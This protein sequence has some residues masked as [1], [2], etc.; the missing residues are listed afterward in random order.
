M[1]RNDDVFKRYRDVS[2]NERTRVWNNGFSDYLVPINMTEVQLDNRLASLSISQEL[3]KIFFI[4]NQAAGIYLHA[5]GTFANKKIA[6]LGGMAVD[7][8]FRNQQVAIKLL[9]EFERSAKERKT[10]ILYLEAIDGN[11]RAISIYKKFGFSSIQKVV[12]LDSTTIYSREIEFQLKKVVGLETIG[13]SENRES[14]WQ[15]KSIHGYDCLGIYQDTTLVG[16]GVF[17]S[18]GDSVIIHQLE[19]QQPSIQIESVLSSLQQLYNPIKWR[20]S[21]LVAD[22]ATTQSLIDNGFSEIVSQ[23]QYSKIIK[24]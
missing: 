21:N 14:L 11:E 12:V 3:S 10:D 16:Y 20:G 8:A 18:Q 9:R 4:E 6:W 2:P 15:N 22:N 7:P 1:E 24:A 23:H 19:L 13:I 17:S 5:E